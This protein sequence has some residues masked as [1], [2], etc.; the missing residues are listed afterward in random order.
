MS[1]DK[2][3]KCIVRFFVTAGLAVFLGSACVPVLA[4][5]YPTRPIRFVVPFAPGG[6]TDTLARTLGQKV[7]QAVGQQLVV[8]NRPG[9]SGNIGTEMVARAAPDG[10]TILL[11][12]I[13]NLAIA[14]GLHDK[15]PYDAIK[16]FSA[17]TQVAASPNLF[18]AHPSVPVR[19]F[20]EFIVYAK[21]N[22]NK[23]NYASSSVAVLLTG[24]LLK[25]AA[26]I[27]MQHVPYKGTAQAVIDVVGGQVQT[28][29]S[30]MASVAPYI[31][32]GKLRPLAVT[33]AQRWSA[34][35]DV[36]T[37]A[38]SGFPGFEATVW[39]G[40]LA[41]AATPKP[42]IARLHNET[43]NALGLPD[44]KERLNNLGFEIVGS[45]PEAFSDYIKK[46]IVKWTR[47]IKQA[48]VK[49]D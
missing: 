33:S 46:E 40:V 49:P 27:E 16:D 20:R 45:T 13:A 47:V 22:P 29:F 12:Y 2:H 14:P 44:V 48:G 36:P 3:S 38:E 42:I 18:V 32:S 24:E 11:G 23:I 31:K 5:S 1:S 6:A 9:A 21:A 43:V 34:A 30:S 37:I 28:M 4:Q 7:G 19:T 15:L 17:I 35:R 39:F 25:A 8:D 41:P 10:Y 26:G